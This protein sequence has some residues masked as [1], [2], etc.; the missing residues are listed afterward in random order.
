MSG[1]LRAEIGGLPAHVTDVV[2]L[3]DSS[4]LVAGIRGGQLMVLGMPR[5]LRAEAKRVLFGREEGMHGMTLQ[6]G[7]CSHCSYLAHSA[8]PSVGMRGSDIYCVFSVAGVLARASHRHGS[9][10]NA[11]S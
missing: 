5:N 3:P 4:A 6:V 9:S 7:P 1:D 10:T 8:D 11:P 2:F